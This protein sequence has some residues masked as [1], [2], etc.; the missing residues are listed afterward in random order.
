MCGVGRVTHTGARVC[1]SRR[2]L[3]NKKGYKPNYG[4]R[5]YTREDR[6]NRVLHLLGGEGP[7]HEQTAP[8]VPRL[9]QDSNV[10]VSELEPGKEVSVPL[11]AGRQ[12]Y[13][14]CA[15]GSATVNGDARTLYMRDALEV[16]NPS[17]GSDD[18]LRFVA[19]QDGAHV[20]VI[21]MALA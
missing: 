3:P 2:I 10:Y 12:A 14:I 11:A 19:G 5:R 7:G 17:S 13:V 6:L 16:K 20:V 1:V 8:D 4:S 18:E 9:H 21:E 15:E